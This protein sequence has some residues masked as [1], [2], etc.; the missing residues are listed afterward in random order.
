MNKL[1]RTTTLWSIKLHSTPSFTPQKKYV[2]VSWKLVLKGYPLPF[3]YFIEINSSLWLVPAASTVQVKRSFGRRV[4][5]ADL[6]LYTSFNLL[7]LFVS[8][9]ID[10]PAVSF[11]L[12][13]LYRSKFQ[14]DSGQLL[15]R[16]LGNHRLDFVYGSIRLNKQN[17]APT[18]NK[19]SKEKSF[20]PRDD[21]AFIV[22]VNLRRVFSVLCRPSAS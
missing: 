12:G 17:V 18:P 21:D 22:R 10:C 6:H 3:Q 19:Q 15:R 9:I 16:Q 8:S 20:S 5:A 1:L 7:L 13:F 4:V 2:E 11:S 14:T